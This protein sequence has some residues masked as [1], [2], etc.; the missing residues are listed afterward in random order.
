MG[1]DCSRSSRRTGLPNPNEYRKAKNKLKNWDAPA[2][3][4]YEQLN[5]VNVREPLTVT[6]NLHE[7]ARYCHLCELRGRREFVVVFPIFMFR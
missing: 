5:A 2:I 6:K 1:D 3:T 7:Y 4:E